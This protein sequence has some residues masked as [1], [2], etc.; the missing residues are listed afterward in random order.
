MHN[1][2]PL[3]QSISNPPIMASCSA[4]LQLLFQMGHV[5]MSWELCALHNENCN[6]LQ[7]IIQIVSRLGCCLVYWRVLI[8]MLLNIL[9]ILNSCRVWQVLFTEFVLVDLAGFPGMSGM[10]GMPGM[11]GLPPELMAKLMGDPELQA[12]MMNPK[13]SVPTPDANR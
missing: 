3:R 5:R 12:A 9:A 4:N 8:P 6:T 2:L 1:Y 11:G 7:L 10:G 13:V